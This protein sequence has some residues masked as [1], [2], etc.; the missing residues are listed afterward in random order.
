MA[1]A[2]MSDAQI[3][4]E[5]LSGTER[6]GV[7]L[8]A[9]G[10]HVA[11]LVFKELR[12]S[13]IRRIIAVMGKISKVP[14]NVYREVLEHF[15]STIAEENELLFG[16]TNK[17]LV[18]RALG[19]D[20]ARNIMGHVN[21]GTGGR[22]EALEMVDSRTLANFLVSEHPQTIALIVA[23]LEP[24]KKVEVIKRLPE[25]IQAEV[26]LRISNMDYISPEI[27]SQVDEVLKRELSRMGT[28]EQTALGGV[29][30]VANMLNIMDKN[31][32]QTIMSKIEEKDPILAEEIRKLMFVFDDLTKIDTRGIQTI[33]KE[34]PNDKLI[35]A[36][37]NSSDAVK[38]KI[39]GAMSQRA[40]TMIKED[41]EAMGPVRV[42]DVE[43]AQQEVV[44]IARKLEQE[45]K[46]M[47]ARG[48]DDDALV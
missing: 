36:L 47:I 9:L 28:I 41:L 12:D 39:F 29:E 42:S 24:E 37:K 13:D 23:H 25:F 43:G 22:L 26:V 20:R 14:I 3:T 34:V 48:G 1:K 44:N 45:G 18:I 30:P 35:L 17:D 11:S 21:M 7:L 15:Y 31:T 46:I 8:S 2:A 32:E 33:L 38:E 6:A 27:I 16:T 4:F 19:E 40:S 5:S 10:E